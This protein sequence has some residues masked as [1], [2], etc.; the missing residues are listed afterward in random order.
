MHACLQVLDAIDDGA[1][2]V[3]VAPT[4]SGKT[5]ISSYCINSVVRASGGSSTSSGAGSGTSDDGIV[6]FVAVGACLAAGGPAC[7]PALPAKLPATG[8]PASLAGVDCGS[9]SLPHPHRHRLLSCPLC[10]AAHQGTG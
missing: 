9:A 8:L 3:I 1:S 4:S 6:V 2:A 10:L 5:F 7:L